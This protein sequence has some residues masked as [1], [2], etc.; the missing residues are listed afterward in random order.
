MPVITTSPH[1][2]MARSFSSTSQTSLSALSTASSSSV[3]GSD[4]ESLLVTENGLKHADIRLSARKYKTVFFVSSLLDAIRILQVPSWQDPKINA[5]N[6]S[7]F[8]VSGSLTNAVF[9]VSCK[10]YSARTV[11]LRIYGSSSGALISRPRELHILHV[12]SSQYGIGPRL[13]GTFA[14]GR[15]EEYFD[16]QAITAHDMRDPRVSRWIGV[17]M[18]ELH[19][20]DIDAIENTDGGAG[21]EWEI[22]VKKNV[23][24]WLP[25]AQEVLGLPGLSEAVLSDL[26]LSIFKSHWDTYLL[27]LSSVDNV[28]RV[29]AHNDAQY[30][31]LLRLT[32]PPPGLDEHRQII[33]VD[34]E[35]ASPNPSAFDIANHFHE[36]TTDYNGDTPHLLKA[37]RY[38]TKEERYNF[39]RAYI[40]HTDLE[41][42][43]ALEEA[44]KEAQVKALDEQ[45]HYWSPSSHAMWAIWAIVQARE[46]VV[47][48]V[49]H[50]EFDYIGYARSRMSGFYRELR[51]LGVSV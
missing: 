36:W 19:S 34:F 23:K 11:L 27:W 21:P 26:D 17:R 15:I 29:F 47:G 5:D 6:V 37:S 7:V 1:P 40:E 49:S 3:L 33:V 18:A 48:R 50:P 4:S 43:V 25:P 46:D 10:A 51:S 16:S 24:C 28:R 22:A 39:I 8:K 44:D 32:N 30:G 13:F 20:V 42:E 35:Y 14:N 12:L 2:A 38:P 41:N 45:V 9:F 31:N